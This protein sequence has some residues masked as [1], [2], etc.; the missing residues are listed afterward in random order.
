MNW[1]PTAAGGFISDCC[2]LSIRKEGSGWRCR[3]YPS[4]LPN[5][6][7][8]A[9]SGRFATLAEAKAWCEEMAGIV[10]TQAGGA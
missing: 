1:H 5:Q 10:S 2:R 8:D 7:P 3:R 9:M 6:K 4:G